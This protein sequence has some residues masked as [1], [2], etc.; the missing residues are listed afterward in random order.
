LL[1]FPSI[2]R[3]RRAMFCGESCHFWREPEPRAV[4]DEA[5]ELTPSVHSQHSVRLAPAAGE[6]DCGSEE[7]GARR[8]GG[9]HQHAS[10]GPF[11]GP[12]ESF[13]STVRRRSLP[14]VVFSDNACEQ[15]VWYDGSIDGGAVRCPGGLPDVWAK[16]AVVMSPAYLGF[17]IEPYEAR[18]L[19]YRGVGICFSRPFG[20]KFM[21]PS[22]DTIL[23]CHGLSMLFETGGMSFSSLIDVGTGSG[24]IGKFAATKAPGEGSLSATLVDIDPAA[25]RYCSSEDFGARPSGLHGREVAWRCE[26]GDAAQMLQEESNFDLVVSNPPYIPARE[27]VLEADGLTQPANFWEGCGLLVRLLELMLEGRFA[28]GAHLVVMIT[29]LTLK[30]QRV[31]ALLSEA[32]SRGVEVRTLLE[33]E[34]AWKAWYAGSGRGPKYLIAETDSERCERQRLGNCEFFIGATKPGDSRIGGDRNRRM[35]YHWH[36]AYVLDLSHKKA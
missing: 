16:D 8:E 18:Y 13:S 32:P 4:M 15:L 9:A 10:R 36:V 26:T 25:A 24:F 28:T 30:S 20:G 2:Y 23:V 33:R 21:Q 29:S 35:D 12:F 5:E 34:I 31:A 14:I 17:A 11:E 19:H 7:G 22:I 27:E 1:E 3:L 6:E